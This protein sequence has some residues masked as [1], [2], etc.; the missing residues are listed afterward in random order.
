VFVMGALKSSDVY[1]EALKRAQQNDE[2]KALLGEPIEAG[3]WVAGSIQVS[4]GS[5]NADITIPLSGPKGS[6]TLHAVATK[7]AGVWQYST[8]EVAPKDAGA[9]I[10]LRP[11]LG[12]SHRSTSAA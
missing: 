2:V 10:D 12:E 9:R 5:G 3:F 1:T 6:A 11:K 8:L 7:T 4:N